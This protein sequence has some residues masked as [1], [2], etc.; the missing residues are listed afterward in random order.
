MLV[1]RRALAGG[2]GLDPNSRAYSLHP[3]KY[4]NGPRQ[5]LLD[6]WMGHKS[7]RLRYHISSRGDECRVYWG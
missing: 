3:R 7:Q 2:S 4:N 1:C 5:T 6:T